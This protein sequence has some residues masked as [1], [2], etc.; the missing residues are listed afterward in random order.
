MPDAAS[1]C[2]SDHILLCERLP[3]PYYVTSYRARNVDTAE[4]VRLAVMENAALRADAIVRQL[5]SLVGCVKRTDNMLPSPLSP[6]LSPLTLAGRHG[7]RL[8]AAA[9]WIDGQTAAEWLVHHGRFSS[10]VVLEIARAML[11]GLVELEKCGICHGDVSLA[12]LL[13]TDAGDAVLILPGLR[14]IVRPEEGYAHADLLPEAFDSLSPERITAGTP[15]NTASDIYACGCVWWQMLCGRPPLAGGT[16]LA[17]LRAAQAGEICDVRRHAPDVP[18]A[19]GGR[20]FRL[21]RART[22]PPARFDG[23]AGR[24]A[25]FA[26]PR[27][28][29]GAGRVP[30]PSW[31]ARHP[32]DDHRAE[33]P[34]IESHS[35]LVGRHGV[36][37]GRD[38]RNLLAGI[39]GS[40]VREQDSGVRG[41]GSVRNRKQKSSANPS[42]LTPHPSSL[43]PPR[44]V[45]AAY[46]QPVQPAEDIV[47]PAGKPLTV[48]IA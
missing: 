44:V 36:P 31:P 18:A 5:E 22:G 43:V 7:Q 21:C 27:W 29:G 35:A 15:P 14:G 6:L 1:R 16:S 38:A 47:L 19:A 12:S 37:F 17:K 34:P 10:E 13:L 30:R 33:S 42:S 41:Q 24:H 48:G 23:A 25:R 46:Q 20:D 4:S 11:A 2:A 40:E 45:P 26:H 28:Q 39:Q 9:S 32:L 3:H 8:F